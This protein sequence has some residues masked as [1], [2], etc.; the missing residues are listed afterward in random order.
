LAAAEIVG[1]APSQ[2]LNLTI[3]KGDTGSGGGGGATN[4]SATRTATT[5]TVVSDTGDDA[6]LAAADGTNAGVMTAAMQTKLVGVATGATAN[7]TDAYLLSRANQTGTQAQS[8]I[9]NLTTDLAAKAP[10]ASPAFTGTPTGITKAHVG[11]GNVDNT[12]D[13]AKPVSSAQQT[14]LNLKADLSLL[15]SY[16]LKTETYSRSEIDAMF[17]TAAAPKGSAPGLQQA[18]T[19]A[20]TDPGGITVPAGAVAVMVAFLASSAADAARV[21]GRVLFNT[22]ATPLTVTATNMGRQDSVPIVYG[23]PSSGA[24]YLHVASPTA[25]A[26]VDLT[27]YFN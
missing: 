6:T 19:T 25:S 23:I 11:L 18:L 16:Y 21:K 9:T 2:T 22:S 24:T 12:A 13:T 8:T 20:N 27:W 4:L 1:T 26:V 10:L 5:V 15:A 3:P 14:A 7:Q 17:A